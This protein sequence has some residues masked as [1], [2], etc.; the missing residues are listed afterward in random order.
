MSRNQY[1]AARAPQQPAERGGPHG[2]VDAFRPLN[3][4]RSAGA[5]H[6]LSAGYRPASRRASRAGARTPAGEGATR[7]TEQLSDAQRQTLRA[8]CD[9]IVPAIE[10]PDDP[11]GFWG[12]TAT[13]LG[14]D[15]GIEELLAA[16]PDPTVRAGLLQLLDVLGD[17]GF[18]RAPSQASRE[19]VLRNLALASPEAAQGVAG[20]TGMALFLHYG[21]PDPRTA[22]NPN[23]ATFGYPGPLGAPPEVPK[24]IPVREPGGDEETLE[25]DVCVVGSG[26]GGGVVAGTLAR[27]GLK[28]VVLE[29]AGY[30]NESDF[31]QL[32]LPAYQE[33]FWR[34]G[35]TPTADGNVTLQAGTTLGGGTTINWTNCLRTTP[36]VR[37]QWAR[38][39]GLEG[40]DG[41]D[42]DRH[43]DHD[44]YDPDTA[45]YL[46]FGDQ[47][48]SKLSTE[49]TFLRDAVEHGAEVMVRTR[50]HRVLVEGGRAAGVE[51]NYADPESGREARVTVRAPRVVV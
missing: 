14:V 50:A 32:E 35:P 49:K 30:F 15:S 44:R 25:A 42:Y 27:N 20:L 1:R 51:A 4:I 12:R 34:G 26:A 6:E 28:V 39:F 33:M 18:G 41:P 38:E 9:T 8:F 17:Q 10:R 40:V 31:A 36:W 3:G 48:G 16:L 45:G 7:M 24:A 46:G 29:A 43:L 21:A 47:S 19:Q 13:D 11:D 5:A 22:S 23:W 37:E 2:F